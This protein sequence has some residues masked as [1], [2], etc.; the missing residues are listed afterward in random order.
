MRRINPVGVEYE[1]F[2]LWLCPKIQPL[3]GWRLPSHVTTG[4]TRGYSHSTPKGLF[5]Y[6]QNEMEWGSRAI[7]K[8]TF[9]MVNY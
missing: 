2:H 3:R 9:L 7:A 5:F 8:P 6:L 4:F 1:W